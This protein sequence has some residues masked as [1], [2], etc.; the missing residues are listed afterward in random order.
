MGKLRKILFLLLFPL[1]IFGQKETIIHITT[2][3]WPQETRWV[4]HADSLYGTI[5]GDVNYSYYKK[6]D[7]SD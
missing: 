4:L 7:C 5:L 3:S 1:I 2:D 6:L